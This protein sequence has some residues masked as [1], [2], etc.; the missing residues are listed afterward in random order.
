M[1]YQR[2]ISIKQP[3]LLNIFEFLI[4]SVLQSTFHVKYAGKVWF[5][6]LGSTLKKCSR[7]NIWVIENKSRGM[8]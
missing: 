8:E 1:H 3:I 6:K 7:G 2:S 4:I 5:K